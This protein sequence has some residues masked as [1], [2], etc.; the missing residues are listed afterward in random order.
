MSSFCESQIHPQIAVTFKNCLVRLN[1]CAK[2]FVKVT[3]SKLYQSKLIYEYN[4]NGF[5]GSAVM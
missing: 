3:G 2:V 4:T 5:Y 1:F